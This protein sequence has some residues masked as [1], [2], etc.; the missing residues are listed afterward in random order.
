MSVV[1]ISRGTFSGGKLLAESLAAKLRYRCIDRDR[2]VAKAATP[3]VSQEMLKDA[4]EKPPSLLQRY[5]HKKYIYLTLIQAAL[6]EERSV[7]AK[8]CITATR[9]ICCC[10]GVRRSSEFGSLRLWNS[11]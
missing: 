5:K 8:W 11:A 6:A 10:R 1:T 7:Q 2:I 3:D 4:L 9:A